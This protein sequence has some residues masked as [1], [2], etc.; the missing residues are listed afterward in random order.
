MVT[1]KRRHNLAPDDIFGQRTGPPRANDPVCIDNEC[2][3]CTGDA[4]FDNGGPDRIAHHAAEWVAQ[5]A[6][7]SI[8]ILIAIPPGDTVNGD[9]AVRQFH[10]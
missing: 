9:A 5:A 1:V 2:F 4:E 6:Q 3:R 8:G 7:K 10:Q